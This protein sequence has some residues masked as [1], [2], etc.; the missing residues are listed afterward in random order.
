MAD[1]VF[2]DIK[3]MPS[4]IGT[5]G[6]KHNRPPLEDS[7]ALDFD[8][9]IRNRGLDQRIA[10]ITESAERAPAIET[11]EAAAQAGDLIAMARAAADQVEAERE[12]LNRPLLT[13]GR[14]LKAKADSFVG[15]METAISGLRA[16]LDAFVAAHP[17]TLARGDFGARVG[18]K[19]NWLFEIVD[20]AKLPLAIRRHPD[21][22]AAMEKVIRGQVRGGARSIAGVKIWSEQVASVR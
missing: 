1:P 10:E 17:E 3:P 18:T 2:P 9:A 16:K 20:P 22:L 11:R 12:T 13:A 19:T 14:T 15:P 7:I 6:P 21:V 5:P 8:E 4:A